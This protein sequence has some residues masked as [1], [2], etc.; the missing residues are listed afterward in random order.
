MALSTKARQSVSGVADEADLLDR[1]DDAQD[2]YPKSRVFIVHWRQGRRVGAL[3]LA[4]ADGD[5]GISASTAEQ[6][7]RHAASQS[8]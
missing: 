2:G 4:G 7:A 5:S 3:E 1:T 8:E 6:V